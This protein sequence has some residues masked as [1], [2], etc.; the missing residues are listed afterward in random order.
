MRET[1]TVTTP[2]RFFSRRSRTARDRAFMGTFA[3]RIRR[4]G[5]PETAQ[6]WA[7]GGRGDGVCKREPRL[8]Y[9]PAESRRGTAG[10]RP[11][12]EG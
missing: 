2:N 6:A 11:E 9:G 1:R 8:D 12:G 4:K 10:R 7:W 5:K 3:G